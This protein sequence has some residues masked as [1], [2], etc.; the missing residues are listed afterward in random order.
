MLKMAEWTDPDPEPEI[1]TIKG[2]FSGN[3]QT[4]KLSLSEQIRWVNYIL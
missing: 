3:E 1:A 2:D 4:P